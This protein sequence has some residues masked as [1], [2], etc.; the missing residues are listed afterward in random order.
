SRTQACYVHKAGKFR[1]GRPDLLGEV[2]KPE[3]HVPVTAVWSTRPPP[4]RA[5]V[6]PATSS[7]ALNLEGQAFSFELMLKGLECK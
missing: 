1:Q 4:S 5:F 6:I 3:E 7:G 2:R